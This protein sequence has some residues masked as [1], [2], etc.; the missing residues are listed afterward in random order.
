MRAG[1]PACLA[2]ITL[3]LALS[4]C[5]QEPQASTQDPATNPTP[6]AASATNAQQTAPPPSPTPSP[7]PSAPGRQELAN[8]TLEVPKGCGDNNGAPHFTNGQAPVWDTGFV[9][10]DEP[11]LDVNL[12]GAPATVL[13]LTCN[14]GGSGAFMHLAAYGPDHE[15]LAS[16]AMEEISRYEPVLTSMTGSAQALELKWDNEFVEGGESDTIHHGSGTGQAVLALTGGRFTVL[17]YDFS[18]PRNTIRL[19]SE[20]LLKAFQEGDDARVRELMTPEGYE[21]LQEELGEADTSDMTVESC[22]VFSQGDGV[23][24]SQDSATCLLKDSSNNKLYEA[25]LDPSLKQVTKLEIVRHGG[26]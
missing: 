4:G 19:T 14:G 23:L 16:F 20:L 2:A 26:C 25:S 9:R 1:V 21:G 22:F 18:D 11:S 10:I 17:D 5:G 13:Y 15:L 3:S 6:F 8:A 24:G 12:D 7:A